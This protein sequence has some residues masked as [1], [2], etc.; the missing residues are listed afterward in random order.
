MF[1]AALRKAVPLRGARWLSTRAS[2]RV[3]DVL[4]SSKDAAADAR[5]SGNVLDLEPREGLTAGAM[6]IGNAQSCTLSFST[7][8]GEEAKVFPL[9][10]VGVSNLDKAVRNGKKR[11]GT[12][13]EGPSG[14]EPSHASLRGPGGASFVVAHQYRRE[15]V[16]SVLLPVKSL[17]DAADFWIH[18]LGFI[19]IRTVSD[20]S[21]LDAIRASTKA[22]SNAPTP[23]VWE[24]THFVMPPV[25]SKLPH[26]TD[27][28]ATVLVS[29]D[30][31]TSVC[32][33]LVEV[34][35]LSPALVD[36]SSVVSLAVPSVDNCYGWVQRRVEV[37]LD[38][39]VVEGE[40]SEPQTIAARRHGIDLSVP[41]LWATDLDG[42]VIR[43]FQ[44]IERRG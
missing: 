25:A 31:K 29:G 13:L 8:P 37:I 7:H 18:T 10:N 14:S 16:S 41:R 2:A 6:S 28:N 5:W 32:V 21:S 26:L 23:V 20:G 40:V 17:E 19:P 30:P 35:D 24:G 11:G 15:P 43:V 38:E 39:P 22:L 12:V 4:L 3:V 42:N 27:T 44:S 36:Q 34:P 33:V 9:V 1:R